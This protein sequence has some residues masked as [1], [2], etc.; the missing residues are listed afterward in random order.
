MPAPAISVVVPDCDRSDSLTQCL[1]GFAAQTL[2][3]DRFE[4]ILEGGGR[5]AASMRNAAVRRARAPAIVVCSCRLRP[6]PE[7]LARCL[8]FHA[9]HAAIHHASLLCYA[10]DSTWRRLRSVPGKTGVQSWQA[11]DWD[12]FTAK[13]AIFESAQFDPAYGCMAGAEL[14]LRLSRRIDLTLH[15]EPAVTCERI[16]SMGLEEACEAHYLTAYY[17]YSL[18]R[19]YP[20]VVSYAPGEMVANSTEMAALLAV[21]RELGRRAAQPDFAGHRMLEALCCR[22][23]EHARAAGWNAARDGRSPNPGDILGPR[24]PPEA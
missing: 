7:L 15:Y 6:L 2:A 24:K 20:G 11:F 13:T 17:Q 18:S 21:A 10:A 4:L 5:D 1:D 14:A 9:A 16:G 12:A 3:R 22:L 8:Q 19:A 23:E